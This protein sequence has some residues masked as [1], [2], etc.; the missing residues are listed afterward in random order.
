MRKQLL[1]KFNIGC[2]Q[3]VDCVQN[4]IMCI[5]NVEAFVPLL[6]AASVAEEKAV[7]FFLL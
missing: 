3:S 5:S 7:L 6:L 1:E 2:T 4:S